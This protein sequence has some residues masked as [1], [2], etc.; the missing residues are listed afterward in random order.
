MLRVFI[1]L[2][3]AV[4]AGRAV[5]SIEQDFECPFDGHRWRQRLETSANAKGLRLDLKQLGDVVQPPSL[6]QCPKCRA[7]MFLEKWEPPVVDTLRPFLAT[8]E[9]AQVAAKYPSYYVLAVVQERLNAPPFHIG[10]SYLRAS[11]QCEARPGVARHCLGRSHEFLSRAFAAMKAD[12]RQYANSA[13][14]LG[15]LERRLGRFDEA[16]ARFRALLT[17]EGFKDEGHQRVINRQMEL[18][19]K[20]DSEPRGVIAAHD[21]FLSAKPAVIENSKPAAVGTSPIP[22]VE[23][24]TPLSLE[25]ISAGSEN[26]PVP[27]PKA[28]GN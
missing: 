23:H 8:D 26:A 15:E 16:D 14:L 9:F 7:V 5:N 24:M 4:V 27:K 3:V 1:F 11:W 25:S 2:F 20:R 17:A 22:R 18:I 28:K 12:D 19:A 6:P 10:H 13:L 21:A